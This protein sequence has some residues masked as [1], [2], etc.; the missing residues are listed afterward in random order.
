MKKIFLSLTFLFAGPFAQATV[1]GHTKVFIVVQDI[2][3]EEFFLERAPVLGCYGLPQG[4]QLSQWVAEYKV[5][6]NVG[7]GSMGTYMENINYLTCAKIVDS[8]ESED[9][10]S[11]KKITLDISQC[12]AKNDAKF[13]TMVRTSAAKNFPQQNGKEV[14]L[15]LVK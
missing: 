5:P 2:Q 1:D 12:E 7:C 8:E 13:I 11:F 15:V 3:S 14:E 10:M 6:T 4:P 9:F